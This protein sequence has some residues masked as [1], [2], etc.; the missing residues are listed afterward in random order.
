M[1]HTNGSKD[2]RVAALH[3]RLA[4]LPHVQVKKHVIS[5]LGGH[6]S[7]VSILINAATY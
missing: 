3:E 2:I 5:A 1:T 6:A 7:R 4:L